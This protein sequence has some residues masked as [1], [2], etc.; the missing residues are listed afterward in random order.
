MRDCRKIKQS[1]SLI[2]GEHS[3]HYRLQEAARAESGQ[4]SRPRTV[5]PGE[6]LPRRCSTLR[7]HDAQP[8]PFAPAT[9]G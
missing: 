2:G 4:T 1:Q 9:T 7:D 8:R 3:R 6:P 5:N